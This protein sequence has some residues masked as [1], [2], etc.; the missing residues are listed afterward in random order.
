MNVN[1]LIAFALVSLMMVLSPGPN[2][3]YLISRSISQGKKAG[4]ISLL[5]V[6][7]GFFIYMLLSAL[8]ITAVLFKLPYLYQV[9]Q[10]LGALYLFWL[11]WNALKPNAQSI[12]EVQNIHQDTPIKLFN[13][14]LIT[15]LLNPKIALMYLALLPQFINL[16]YSIFWQSVSLGFIQIFIS[17]T[18]NGLIVL[19]A[20]KIALFLQQNMAWAKVQ[21][22]LMGLVLIVLAIKILLEQ[23]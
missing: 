4:L 9:I 11:A 23:H 13:M 19:S 20:A 10:I 8:G 16:K 17:L 15:N 22:Y 12:F 5:G 2:M 14:G 7:C 3:I 21:K 6:G 18:V 1:D